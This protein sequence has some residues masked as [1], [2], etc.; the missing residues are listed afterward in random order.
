MIRTLHLKICLF[1]TSDIKFGFDSLLLKWEW[2]TSES[3]FRKI[4]AASYES[5]KWFKEVQTEFKF[6]YEKYT[7]R[8]RSPS[9]FT[10]KVDENILGEELNK[11]ISNRS[12]NGKKTHLTDVIPTNSISALMTSMRKKTDTNKINRVIS[13]YTIENNTFCTDI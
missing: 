1:Q 13:E 3:V 10:L 2:T 8:R 7:T 11:L 5:C 6:S 12:R 4:I 9:K